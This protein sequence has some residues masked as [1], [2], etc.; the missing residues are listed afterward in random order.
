MKWHKQPDLTVLNPLSDAIPCAPLDSSNERGVV[1]NAVED[2]ARGC[3]GCLH[4]RLGAV[5][6]DRALASVAAAHLAG[7]AW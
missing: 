4:V 7:G 1:D 6:G 3:N 5:L 2:L